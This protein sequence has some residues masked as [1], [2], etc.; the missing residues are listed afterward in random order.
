MR[1]A[2]GPLLVAVRS[3]S[4]WSSCVAWPLACQL[5]SGPLPEIASATDQLGD[6]AAFWVLGLRVEGERVRGRSIIE[7]QRDAIEILVDTVER[8]VGL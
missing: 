2:V 1:S 5:V 4:G 7:R 6:Q 3:S 8:K